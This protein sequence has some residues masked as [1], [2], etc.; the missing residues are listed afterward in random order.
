MYLDLDSEENTPVSISGIPAYLTKPAP[1][2][3]GIEELCKHAIISD[4]EKNRAL[5]KAA[6]K[7]IT[8]V[9]IM[10]SHFR[11]QDPTVKNNN[12]DHSYQTDD[13]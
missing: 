4:I 5:T 13:A 11:S 1:T 7:F 8:L 10:K 3:L 2:T 6:E 9:P 12:V